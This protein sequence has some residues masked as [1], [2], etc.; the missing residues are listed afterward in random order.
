MGAG[1]E[2]EGEWEAVLSMPLAEAAAGISIEGVPPT[3][4]LRLRQDR[5]WGQ[6]KRERGNGRQSYPCH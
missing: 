5:G 4:L 2:V 1:E 3:S 6:G